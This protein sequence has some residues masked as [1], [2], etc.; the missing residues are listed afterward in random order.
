[1]QFIRRF[2]YIKL[3]AADFGAALVAWMCFYLLRKYLL[4]EMTG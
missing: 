4:N 2:Q 1:L 3:V